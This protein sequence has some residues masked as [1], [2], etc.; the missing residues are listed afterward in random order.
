MKKRLYI[1]M[2]WQKFT[3]SQQMMIK[4]PKKGN[5][6]QEKITAAEQV[7]KGISE[8]V[9]TVNGRQDIL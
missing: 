4:K 1:E 5:K 6:C 2:N 9:K 7:A 3:L 8:N